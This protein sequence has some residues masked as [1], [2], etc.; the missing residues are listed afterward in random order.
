MAKN[1]YILYTEEEG[2]EFRIV[3]KVIAKH[4]PEDTEE[5]FKET[6]KSGVL[7]YSVGDRTIK[8]KPKYMALVELTDDFDFV[9]GKK[10]DSR[11]EEAKDGAKKS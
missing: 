10:R 6:V 5:F 11:K 1:K 8:I 7:L 2:G 3:D 9:L 4:T